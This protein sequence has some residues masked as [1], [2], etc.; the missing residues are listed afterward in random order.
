VID[1]IDRR[2]NVV[3]VVGNRT[4]GFLRRQ[5]ARRQAQLDTPDGVAIAPGRRPDRRRFAQPPHPPGRQADPGHHHDCRLRREAATTATTSRR[6]RRRST[7]R[8]RCS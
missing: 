4:S 8:T 3:T 5:R 1:R 6:S 7:H 2:S